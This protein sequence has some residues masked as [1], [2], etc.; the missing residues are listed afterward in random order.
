MDTAVTAS[1]PLAIADK[2]SLPRKLGF[3]L[4]DYACNIYW[5]SLSLFLLF[6]YTDVV[7]LSA[8][9]AGWIYMVASI[10]DG[11]IDPLIGAL[12]DRTRS[13]FGRYRPYILFGALPLGISFCLLYY[14]PP[15]HGTGLVAW[16][17]ATH[18]LLRTAYAVLNI[19]FMSLNARMTTS[20]SERSTLAGFRMLF[21]TLAGLT[22]AYSTQ[23]L[24]AR[25]A[26]TGQ[27][28][29][30]TALLL[31]LLATALFPVVFAA[32]RE[33][34]IEATDHAPVR[35]RD[36][37][38]AVRANRAFWSVMLAITLAAICATAWSKSILYYFKY[39]LEN[40][41]A[42]RFA[43]SINAAA[44]LVIIPIWMI[45]SRSLG[46]RNAWFVA[47]AIGLA[48]L[49]FFAVTDV[50]SVALTVGLLLYMQVAFLGLFLTFWSMMPDTVEYGEWR[51][52][53]RAESFVFGLAQFFMKVALGFGAGLFG[54]ALDFVGYV[55]NVPQSPQTLAG[56]KNVM[57]FM[58]AIGITVGIVAIAL[59]P[60][61]RGVHERIVA[62]IEARK[63]A[64]G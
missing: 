59:Y 60:M 36:Y 4:G 18:V 64:E 42:S 63:R 33:P 27:G 28:Y 30:V 62:E 35:M 53:V 1:P 17:L 49:V 52:G 16:L 34:P 44:G 37:W 57:V 61:R 31:G 8:A 20:S 15:F 41:G 43:L 2:L 56:M 13:R 48:G 11:A 40:E 23:P 9:T 55:P 46:K 25:F 24:V 54:W 10:W 19:P 26:G 6:F 47:S 39:Y 7:G 38:A 32:T 3:T 21:A 14:K 51:S 22:V 5:Q 29:M 58:P 12:A 50:R 45:A